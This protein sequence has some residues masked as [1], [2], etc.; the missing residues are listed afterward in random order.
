M[1]LNRGHRQRAQRAFA[2]EWHCR[3]TVH[4]AFYV[5]AGSIRIYM[6]M[7]GPKEAVVLTLRQILAVRQ[8]AAPRHERA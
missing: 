2:R 7:Q 6:Y 5:I 8:A 4:D 3:N 1:G